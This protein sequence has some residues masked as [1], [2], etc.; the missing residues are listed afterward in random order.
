M[1]SFMFI[2][3]QYLLVQFIRYVSSMDFTNIKKVDYGD[4]VKFTFG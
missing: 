2:P 1:K 3:E 4:D